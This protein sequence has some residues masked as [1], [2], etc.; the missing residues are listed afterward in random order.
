[1]HQGLVLSLKNADLNEKIISPSNYWLLYV[2]KNGVVEAG[3]ITWLTT[4]EGYLR[5]MFQ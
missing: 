2:Y 5:V 1:M 3:D 4:A